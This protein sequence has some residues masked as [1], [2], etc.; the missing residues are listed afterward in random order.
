MN[1]MM[2]KFPEELLI[3]FGM[4]NMN[5]A[6]VLGYISFYFLFIQLCL[7]IQAGNYGFGLVSIEENELTADFLVD[8][9]RSVV[10]KFSPANWWL[11]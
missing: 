1:E 3:A 11:P 4:N 6:T 10:H 9:N 8:V 7:A 5:Y 2:E